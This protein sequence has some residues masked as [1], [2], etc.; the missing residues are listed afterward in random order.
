MKRSTLLSA[1]LYLLLALSLLG[2]I[3][4]C[5]NKKNT[6]V[7]RMYHNLTAHYNTWWNGNESLKDAIR[8]LDKNVKD[9]FTEILPVFKLGSKKDL[10]AINPK[11]DRAIEKASKVI[12]N[13]SMYFNKKEY[14]RWIDDSYLMIG[15]A[16]F[17]KQE[18][19][20]ARRTF[21]FIVNRYKDSPLLPEIYIWTALTNNQMGQFP[22][23]DQEL[24]KFRAVM[25]RQ[26]QPRSLLLF[27]YKTLAD[28]YL[29]QDQSTEAIK[30]LQKALEYNRSKNDKARLYYILGQLY[31]KAGQLGTASQMFAEVVKRNPR[32]DMLFTAQISMAR[33]FDPNTGSAEKVEKLLKGLLAEEKNKD[34][35]DQIY[36]ALAELYLRNNRKTE[37]IENLRLS[38]AKSKNNDFQRVQSSLK[39][40]D[41]YFELPRYFEAQAYYDTALQAFPRESSE[42]QKLNQKVKVL[43]ELVNHLNVI[44]TEDSLQ[45]VAALPE[46]ER[47]KIIDGIIARVM[48]ER[49][50]K[51]EEER[52]RQTEMAMGASGMSMMGDR[53]MMPMG[54]RAGGG[55]YF[56]NPQ[57][58]SMGFTEFKRR[59]GNRKLEDLWRLSN[60]QL[61]DWGT[62]TQNTQASNDTSTSDTSARKQASTDPL[63]RDT[64]L[65][66]LPL[67][68][69]ALAE[70]NTRLKDA[71]FNAAFVYREGLG[72]L[73]NASKT[74]ETLV[75]RFPDT[76]SNPYYLMSCYQLVNINEK[77]GN[78]EKAD[79]YRNLIVSRYPTTDY[80]LILGNPEYRKEI[81]RKNNLA[82]TLYA[83][84]YD[85]WKSG[86]YYLVVMNGEDARMRFAGHKLLPQFELLRA[87]A[88]GKVAGNDSLVSNLQ[89][90][91]TLYAATD[92]G[93]L[94]RDVLAKMGKTSPELAQAASLSE[95]T[96]GEAP[97]PYTFDNKAD[98]FF[99]ALV[100]SNQVDINAFRIRIADFNDRAFRLETFNVSTI[101]FNDTLQMIS[102]GVFK[103]SSRALDYRNQFLDSEY[104]TSMLQ[105][106]TFYTFVIS[107]PNYAVFYQ[108]KD[109][110][111]YLKF[112]ET[113]YL[114]K[115]D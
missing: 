81:E 98:H 79:F 71:Y 57:A 111:G 66:K 80:A 93:R 1:G 39:L 60:K 5:S 105:G 47:L 17:Y 4:S 113:Q 84:T 3:A 73:P 23:A 53:S 82:A 65:Q 40:A 102:I 58:V 38:V 30:A 85:A 2:G 61:T 64:Y 22:R 27:Y 96:G 46:A 18:Y 28:Y 108:N 90:V 76:A 16:Y 36:Y 42:Y 88:L 109:I 50:K 69:D 72:D 7:R 68:P 48:E 67:T 44:Q 12:Q 59:W 43:T 94:A 89:K 26:P 56:Y 77:L 10:A 21:E 52:L 70:S 11:A 14:N 6:M 8:D 62:E 31:W 103:G 32:Y 114:G 106:K 49:K 34:Y 110:K 15:K 95:K 19:P 78:K 74:F 115:K 51:E 86:Q 13:N 87:F 9:N 29:K 25:K 92:A 112:F 35:Q 100:N 91:A 41:L 55:W 20:A 45:R 63:K 75:E 33:C 101:V 107:T 97:L 24:D 83:E 54:N 99:I 37:A 104:I